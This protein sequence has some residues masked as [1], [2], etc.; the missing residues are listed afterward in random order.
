MSKAIFTTVLLLLFSMNVYGESEEFRKELAEAERGDAEAQFTLGAMYYKGQGVP[1]D[2]KE[3]VRW[4]TKA[5]EQGYV[6]AQSSLGSMYLIGNNIQQDY[7]KAAKWLTKA[8]EQGHAEAQKNLAFM[9]EIGQGVPQNYKEAVKWFR[10]AAEQGGLRSQVKLGMSYYFGFSGYSKNYQEA[11]KWYIKAANQNDTYSQHMVASMYYE[12]RGVLL[13]YQKAANWYHKAAKLGHAGSQYELGLMY[14]NGLGVKQSFEQALKWYIK[15]AEQG[16]SRAQFDLGIMYKKGLGVEQNDE[17]ADSWF[18]TSILQGDKKAETQ[19]VQGWFIRAQMYSNGD[20]VI[21]SYKQ[22]AKWYRKAAEHGYAYAQFNLAGMYKNGEGV[23]EDY[24]EA[25]KWILLAG[26]NGLDVSIQK[27]D[28]QEK[29][30][31]SGIE[32]AQKRAREFVE[33]KTLAAEQTNSERRVQSSGT[34]FFVDPDGYLVTA[35]HVVE[36]AK[37][38]VVITNKGRFDAK[39]VAKD[40]NSDFAILKAQGTMFSS[41]NIAPSSEVKTGDKVFTIGFPNIDV[42]GTEAKYTEGS[43]SSLS[44]IKNNFRHF[45]ISVPVQSGN[46]GGPLIDSNGNVIG[47]IVSKLSAIQ[48]LLYKGTIPQNVNYAIKSSFVLPY[49]ESIPGIEVSGKTDKAVDK[50]TA[51]Q[52]SKNATALILCY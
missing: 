14:Y 8:A 50:Q 36:E 24:V 13:D 33:K 21:Q 43:I 45:Q 1:Q 48:M 34:G 19:G 37:S 29:L 41:L 32:E 7:T 28:L 9:Y 38:I 23:V 20:G 15:A 27:M 31:P 6:E 42:Q 4:Y 10:K 49:L 52:K 25:Y 44:G 22:A 12:G 3:A 40:N 16:H 47:V 2:Y 11:F 17:Q 5:A 46:S 51:I 18:I 30:S 39:V 35:Y 26:M